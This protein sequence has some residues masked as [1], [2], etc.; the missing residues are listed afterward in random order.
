MFRML[1]I[2]TLIMIAL[3]FLTKAKDY[4]MDKGS[5]AKDVGEVIGKAIKISH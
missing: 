4:A 2:V 3:P 1:L 5:R